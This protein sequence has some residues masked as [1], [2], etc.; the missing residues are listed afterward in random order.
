MLAIFNQNTTTMIDSVGTQEFGTVKHS[1]L[2]VLERK[3][4]KKITE[5]YS[6]L[7]A[8]QLLSSVRPN[9]VSQK[10]W[11]PK[12]WMMN[13]KKKNDLIKRAVRDTKKSNM[14]IT[15]SDLDQLLHLVDQ[16]NELQQSLPFDFDDK[17][18]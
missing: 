13:L 3:L 10:E 8:L 2:S 6:T 18:Q 14:F 15:E 11:E 1:H 16:Y 17:N 12:D 5:I 9:S 4:L 7:D